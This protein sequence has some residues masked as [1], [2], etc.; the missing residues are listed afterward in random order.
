MGAPR[1][2]THVRAA[3]ETFEDADNSVNAAEIVPNKA[4]C[5]V[6]GSASSKPVKI[7]NSLP[8][9]RLHNQQQLFLMANKVKTVI[10]CT[11]THV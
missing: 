1:V 5:L 11:N 4:A 3:L 6:H 10:K 9:M 8:L 2:R 7:I